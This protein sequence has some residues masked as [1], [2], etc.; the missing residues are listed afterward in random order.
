[1]IVRRR[2]YRVIHNG[3]CRAPAT[4]LLPIHN[5]NNWR[6]I[7]ANNAANGTRQWVKYA[8]QFA[9]NIYRHDRI[10]LNGCLPNAAK[11][12]TVKTHTTTAPSS[13]HQQYAHIQRNKT[14]DTHIH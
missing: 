2:H 7:S 1:M 8:W 14:K 10:T 3:A 5:V 6:K 11:P 4:R 9:S 13:D 12:T